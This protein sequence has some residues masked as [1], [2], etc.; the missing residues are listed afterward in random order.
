MTLRDHININILSIFMLALSAS[1][2]SAFDFTAGDFNFK[3]NG[4]LRNYVDSDHIKGQKSKGTK[5]TGDVNN[6]WLYADVPV[7]KDAGLVAFADLR[8]NLNI[9]NAG[10]NTATNSSAI[11]S[12]GD[13]RALFGVKNGYFSIGAGRDAHQLWTMTR[14]NGIFDEMFAS[15]SSQIHNLGGRRFNNAIF[16]KVK[17]LENWEVGIDYKLSETVTN[18]NLQPGQLVIGSKINLGQNLLLQGAWMNGLPGNEALQGMLV[19]QIPK[20]S[21]KFSF[22]GSRNQVE[23]ERWIGYEIMYT[24]NLTPKLD[25]IA[26]VG[27][28]TRQAGN[29]HTYSGGLQYKFTDN[30]RMMLRGTKWDTSGVTYSYGNAAKG[31][32]SLGSG[33]D[34]SQIGLGMHI[35]F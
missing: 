14:Y 5:L 26:G 35:L 11:P 12:I 4:N 32:D 6:I 15:P 28:N 7:Y 10:A 22:I 31:S 3:V 33:T 34:R 24:Y 18:N 9:D 1:S 8:T 16:G 29:L 19:W 23:Y 21:S 17:L 25:L 13:D 2:A 27:G 30:V 20:Y